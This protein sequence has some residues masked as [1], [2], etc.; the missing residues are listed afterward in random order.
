MESKIANRTSKIHL[1]IFDAGGVM[2]RLAKSWEEACRRAGVPYP[3]IVMRPEVAAAVRAVIDPSERG[4][5]TQEQFDQRVSELLGLEP[6][7][8]S[9]VSAAWLV[10]PYPGIEALI[11][12]LAGNGVSLACLSNTNERH[13]GIMTGAGYHASLPV[14]HFSHTFASHLVGIRKPEPGIYEHVEKTTGIAPESI[15]FFDDRPDNTAAAAKRGWQTLT[16]D[17]ARPVEQMTDHLIDRGLLDA[18]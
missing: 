6:E 15:L 11:E 9:K 7:Q 1:V 17:A 16:I 10:E 4:L 2:V 3:E 12:R 8:L 13:W 18:R 5:V 14:Q